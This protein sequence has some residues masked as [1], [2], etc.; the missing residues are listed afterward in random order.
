[1]TVDAATIAAGAPEIA[2]EALV[3]WV[4]EIAEQTKPDAV[5]WCDGSIEERE[6]LYEKMVEAAP[7]SS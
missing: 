7:S 6:R 4:T 3:K 2:P 1:M 5:H